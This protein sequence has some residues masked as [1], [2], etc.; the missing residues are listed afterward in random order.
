MFVAGS[1]L[2]AAGHAAAAGHPAMLVAGRIIQGTGAAAL[3]LAA[4]GASGRSSDQAGPLMKCNSAPDP[5]GLGALRV[6]R[7]IRRRS[8]CPP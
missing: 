2:F 7:W 5:C 1:T 6:V 4:N 8:G 3:R